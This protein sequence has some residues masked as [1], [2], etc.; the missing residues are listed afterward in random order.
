MAYAIE[1]CPPREFRHCT[2]DRMSV[3]SLFVGDFE[4]GQ[5]GW[6]G[7]IS[8]WEL[9][10]ESCWFMPSASRRCLDMMLLNGG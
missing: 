10:A 2:V 1:W 7:S 8:G 5:P 6:A 4:L 9:G 3:A